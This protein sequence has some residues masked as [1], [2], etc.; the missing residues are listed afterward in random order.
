MGYYTLLMQDNSANKL[1]CASL[2]R[3]EPHYPPLCGI[4]QL[5]NS[6]ASQMTSCD[7]QVIRLLRFRNWSFTINMKDVDKI[8]VL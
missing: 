1:Q 8:S 6:A 5:T 7:L 2:L 3:F 4:V